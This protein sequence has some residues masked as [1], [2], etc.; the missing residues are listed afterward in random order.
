MTRSRKTRRQRPPV[1]I[2]ITDEGRGRQRLVIGGELT[3]GGPV[4]SVHEAFQ[5]RGKFEVR[6]LRKSRS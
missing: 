6:D 2:T 4:R 3:A 5:I 1:E